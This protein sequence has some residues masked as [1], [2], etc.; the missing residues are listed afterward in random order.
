MPFKWERKTNKS[1]TSPQRMQK[2]V[3]EVIA[4]GKL[5]TTAKKFNIDKMTLRRYTVK[6]K[7]LGEATNFVPN[8]KSSQTFNF[9]EERN[10]SQYLLTASKMNYGFTSKEARK[11]A[12]LYAI[13]NNKRIP[14]NWSKTETA[15]YDW[16]R[17]F[18]NRN[19]ELSLRTP[20]PTSLSRGT[21]FNQHTVGEFFNLLRNLIEREHFGPESIYNCDETGVQNVHKPSKII[22]QKGQKQVSKVTSG[23]RGQTVTVLC[24]IS[25]IGT[26]IPPFLYTHE[27]ENK[28][29]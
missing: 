25:A 22:S 3:L 26:T 2:A 7:T 16:L 12:Y 17:G 18:M 23:E 15:T 6:Y 20:E 19:K 11:F 28:I 27:L 1:P 9:E 5:R 13:K 14:E 4:G 24:T 8:Y 10:L 21:A 29:T